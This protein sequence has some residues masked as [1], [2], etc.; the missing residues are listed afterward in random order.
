MVSVWM[1]LSRESLSL[2]LM[3]SSG[4]VSMEL[5]VLF[6]RRWSV[7]HMA[8]RLMLAGCCNSHGQGP[9]FSF[10]K[11]LHVARLGT[12]QLLFSGFWAA[13]SQLW[14]FPENKFQCAST[15]QASACITL[16]KSPLAKVCHMAKL[17]QYGGIYRRTSIQ[18]GAVHWEGH[19]RKS[20]IAC[21]HY[22]W[23]K[24]Y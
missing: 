15:Y 22:L 1:G 14:T 19:H 10:V 13:V 7:H 9:R 20:I 4:V 23:E 2:L 6:P 17:S 5:E 21:Q 16:A 11:N 3:A 8:G 24:E 18:G 12:S